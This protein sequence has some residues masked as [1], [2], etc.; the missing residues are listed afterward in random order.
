MQLLGEEVGEEGVPRRRFIRH[1][2]VVEHREDGEDSNSARS[3]ETSPGRSY[4]GDGGYE[5]WDVSSMTDPQDDGEAPR[6]GDKD[7]PSGAG[8]GQ[9]TLWPEQSRHG[10]T[11]GSRQ[12]METDN[13]QLGG[14][15]APRSRDDPWPPASTAQHQDDEERRLTIL[16]KTT[17][18]A[19]HPE[20]NCLWREY[21]TEY[22]LPDSDTVRTVVLLLRVQ[23]QIGLE[24]RVSVEKDGVVCR[25]KDILGQLFPLPRGECVLYCRL[26]H[27]NTM[28]DATVIW[29][30]SVVRKVKKLCDLK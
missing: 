6:D 23:H 14:A 1:V 10:E 17:N 27:N 26:V 11:E 9:E 7:S 29:D 13:E 5:G 19:G 16:V 8:T 12:G 3:P 25:P 30:D 18:D 15:R 2:I 28:A 20:P 24:W 4:S 21:N 22:Q